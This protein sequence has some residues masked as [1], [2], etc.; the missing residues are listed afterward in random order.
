MRSS[1]EPNVRRLAFLISVVPLALIGCSSITGPGIDLT[2]IWGWEYNLNP[3]GSDMSFSLAVAGGHVT[4]AG[5]SH[6]IGPARTPDSLTVIGQHHG[7]VPYVSFDL[8][9][10]FASGSV[11]RYVGHLVGPDELEGTWTAGDQPNTVRF[12]RQQ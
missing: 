9:I 10:R 7:T 4:G 1:W 8:T 11:V 6:G 2:G 3:A 12:Y 5:I